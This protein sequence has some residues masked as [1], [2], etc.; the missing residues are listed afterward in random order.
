MTGS[1]RVRRILDANPVWLAPMAGVNDAVFRGICQRMGAG[2]TYTEMISATGLHYHFD[3]ETSQRL[4]RL[5]DNEDQVAVQLF[6]AQPDI[7]ARQASAV[8]ELLGARVAFIDINMGCPVSK[9]VRKGE[10][11]ALMDDP[12]RAAM[13][14][15]KTVTMLEGRGEDGTD[16]PVTVKFRKGCTAHSDDPILFA[17]KMQEAGA[18]ALAVHGRYADQLYAGT[19]DSEVIGRI[20]QAV[21]IPVLGSGDIWSAEDALRMIRPADEQGVGADGVLIARGSQGNP[22]LFSQVSALRHGHEWTGPTYQEVFAVMGE[23]AR[24]IEAVFGTK[25]LVRMRK[26][27]M[28]YC[29]GF[30]V[31]STFRAHINAISTMGDLEALIETYR[32]YLSSQ[33]IALSDT[34]AARRSR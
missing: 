4:L 26:H 31:A 24:G 17:L 3:N 6:G 13:I 30:P 10:G 16:I 9:V 14:V 22:W 1:D 18:S 20:A 19:S 23:H 5:S 32:A 2:L 33:G 15:T 8:C 29:H 7:I 27:A 34:V 12:D 25:A 11:S 21:D 28:W